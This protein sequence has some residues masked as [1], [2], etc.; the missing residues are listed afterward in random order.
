MLTMSSGQSDDTPMKVDALADSESPK[1]DND[2]RTLNSR[3][4]T[5]NASSTRHPARVSDKKVSG[6]DD[7]KDQSI[8]GLSRSFSVNIVGS[9]EE[10]EFAAVNDVY[11]KYSLISGPD[12]ILSSGTDVGIT[13]IARYRLMENGRHKFV[14]NQPI[15]VS[16]RS[17]N[18]YGWPQ[19]VVSVYNFDTFRNDQILGY[20][21]IHLPIS[22][23]ISSQESQEVKIYSP[24]SSS[25][26]KQILSWVAGRKPELVDSKLFAQGSCRPTLQMV[27]VG[28]LLLSLNLTT[29]D[30]S[31]NGY[32]WR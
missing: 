11:I 15:S 4:E 2:S 27:A 13:Q 21:C 3:R 14:W 17:F 16:Y 12:W 6:A 31:N 29:K 5:E 24:Q 22:T 1:A 7:P 32:S 23:Q 9:L 18:Y 26:L 20:G 19:V 28:K 25:Y 10:G 30:V 8:R